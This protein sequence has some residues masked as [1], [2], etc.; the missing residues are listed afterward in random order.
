MLSVSVLAETEESYEMEILKAIADK[1][2]LKHICIPVL[3]EDEDIDF[4]KCNFLYG[5]NE[6]GN[7]ISMFVV[8]K[9]FSKREL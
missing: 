2:R 5:V 7:V 4:T 9:R 6:N 8:K 1:I 3:Y